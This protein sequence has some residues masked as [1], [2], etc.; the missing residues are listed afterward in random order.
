MGCAGSRPHT[1]LSLNSN[2]TNSPQKGFILFNSKTI[3]YLIANEA[4]TKQKLIQ[5]CEPK[6]LKSIVPT[7]SSKT[8][9][10][11]AKKNILTTKTDTPPTEI[12]D[13]DI[14]TTPTY[15]SKQSAIDAAVDY[16]LK[17]AINDFDIEDFKSSNHLS[18]KQIRKDIMK[19]SSSRPSHSKLNN[20]ITNGHIN[21]SLNASAGASATL[22]RDTTKSYDMA[23]YKLALNVA[24]DEFGS[25]IQENFIVINEFVAKMEEEA[26]QAKIP[27][28][29][30]NTKCREDSPEKYGD[31]ED[32]EEALKLKEALELARQNFYKGK[33]SMV[34]LTKT[35]GYVVKEVKDKDQAKILLSNNK[36]ELVVVSKTW[37]DSDITALDNK[38]DNEKPNT[39]NPPEIKIEDFDNAQQ[40]EENKQE[41]YL[42]SDKV[43]TETESQSVSKM[44]IDEFLSV[45]NDLATVLNQTGESIVSYSTKSAIYNDQLMQAEHNEETV[46]F[47]TA[48]LSGESL[49]ENLEK[50]KNIIEILNI[51]DKK[52]YNM[53][54]E[55]L[56]E[57]TLNLDCVNKEFKAYLI[58]LEDNLKQQKEN[59]LFEKEQ[60]EVFANHKKIFEYKNSEIKNSVEQ[61]SKA[62]Q[63]LPHQLFVSKGFPHPKNANHSFSIT[64]LNTS[65]FSKD[66]EELILNRNK[67][68]TKSVENVPNHVVELKQETPN[69]GSGK[70]SPA[71]HRMSHPIDIRKEIA[72]SILNIGEVIAKTIDYYSLENATQSQDLKELIKLSEEQANLEKSLKHEEQ[73][74][75]QK[76]SP[77]DLLHVTVTNSDQVN[78]LTETTPESSA[79]SLSSPSLGGS[80][81]PVS[82]A[83]GSISPT[84][85][86]SKQAQI[87]DV[88]ENAKSKPD[89]EQEEENIAYLSDQFERDN[90]QTIFQENEL[91]DRAKSSSSSSDILSSNNDE[92]DNHDQVEQSSSQT[93]IEQFIEGIIENASDRFTNEESYVLAEPNTNEN[94]VVFRSQNQPCTNTI[95]PKSERKKIETENKVKRMSLDEEIFFR[96]EEVDK[97]VKYMNETC[98]E[99]EDDDE[100]DLDDENFDY[101]ESVIDAENTNDERLFHPRTPAKI[102][103]EVRQNRTIDLHE[104]IKQISNVIQD[105]VQTINVRNGSKNS[106]N[107]EELTDHEDQRDKSSSKV[108]SSFE[109]NINNTSDNNNADSEDCGSQNSGSG[110]SGGDYKS[111]NNG[112]ERRDSNKRASGGNNSF[113]NI[114]ISNR[115]Q[116]QKLLTKQISPTKEIDNAK[117]AN[118]SNKTISSSPDSVVNNRNHNGNKVSRSKLPVRK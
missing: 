60:V 58:L 10:V 51:I 99:N 65:D 100:D 57:S 28:T 15:K 116:Q 56:I 43:S 26:R 30:A 74:I 91:D 76:S 62:I 14:S 94:S 80:A 81:S 70:A 54:D 66:L 53:I 88:T 34:C 11:K 19:K 71:Q 31:A 90:K 103:S 27:N 7:S 13:I 50:S 22:G 18:M 78:K 108:V 101:D 64:S 84:A 67:N 4:E 29:E 46:H 114:P 45:K 113:S 12:V 89:P 36:E 118:E 97:K 21:G 1:L 85:I 5:R 44:A 72:F 82:L 3:E 33:M 117:I 112:L 105:L 9:L 87:D 86:E 2:T 106:I 107:N 63:N 42:T 79:S 39:V 61:L 75:E 115:Q 83:S 55:K 37:T 110:G 32:D 104:E 8:S 48:K 35:G 92:L 25:F 95:D 93:I 17:Y 102:K 49:L 16:V 20:S 47:D 98:S 41:A 59:L 6:L 68:A 52:D 69:S 77:T 23:F 38:N 24:I 73:V 109:D 111:R 40:N 96:L